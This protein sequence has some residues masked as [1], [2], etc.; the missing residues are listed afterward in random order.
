[1]RRGQLFAISFGAV[2]SACTNITDHRDDLA[3][4]ARA[5]SAPTTIFTVVEDQAYSLPDDVPDELLDIANPYY[6]QATTSLDDAT[7]TAAW[8]TTA[9]PDGEPSTI[10]YRCVREGWGASHWAAT[11][12]AWLAPFDVDLDDY[13]DLV[14]FTATLTAAPAATMFSRE[15]ATA[16]FTLDSEGRYL[17]S[18]SELVAVEEKTV[19]GHSDE[20]LP[21]ARMRRVNAS[22]T[23]LYEDALMDRADYVLRLHTV[24]GAGPGAGTDCSPGDPEQSVPFAAEY[25]LVRVGFVP[26][27][28]PKPHEQTD[29]NGE[30]PNGEEQE[31]P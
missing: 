3:I 13:P 19:P 15:A 10:V 8:V 9:S 29:P 24:G 1:M 6:A 31:T 21:L 18:H 30:A 22:R 17:H 14:P 26:A 28:T 12:R 4:A 27:A 2:A 23:G 5:D 25:W 16:T 11:A 7:V 20:D